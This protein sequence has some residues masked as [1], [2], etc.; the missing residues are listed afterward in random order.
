L[1]ERE[2]FTRSLLALQEGKDEDDRV[3][4]ILRA[5]KFVIANDEEY[6]ITRRM[7]RK[8]GMF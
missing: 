8:L 1:A 2:R 6:A 4:K 3:L 5:L 7:G